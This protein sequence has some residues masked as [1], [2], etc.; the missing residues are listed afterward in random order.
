MRL[1]KLLDIVVDLLYP[2]RCPVCRDIVSKGKFIC[3]ECVDKLNYVQPPYC[4]KCGKHIDSEEAEY[5]DDCK[6]EV[7]RYRKG[8]PVFEYHGAIKESVMAFKYK[9]KREYAAFYAEE[10]MKKH[11][12][13]LEQVGADALIP[14]PVHKKKRRMRGYNQ[15]EVLANALAA[16]LNIPCYNDTLVRV[17]NTKVQKQLDHNQRKK[18][19]KRAFKRVQDGVKLKTVILVDDIYTSGAT[20]EACTEVLL[21]TGVEEVYYVSVCIGK[22]QS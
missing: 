12:E 6:K 8:F 7:R 21:A 16:R 9:N 3:T 1:S 18:N 2:R 15:A 4:Y 11:G 22:G 19:L 14:V 5:C 10:I 20:I 17:E 13:A